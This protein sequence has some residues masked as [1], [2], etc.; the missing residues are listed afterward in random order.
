MFRWPCAGGDVQVPPGVA[1]IDGRAMCQCCG[2]RHDV[3]FDVVSQTFR[4]REHSMLIEE[5][6]KAER[7][8][9]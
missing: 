2:S 3:W 6:R 5:R 8:A 9:S 7:R 4:W 1:V